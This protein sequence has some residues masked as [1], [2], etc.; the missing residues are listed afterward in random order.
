LSITLWPTEINVLTDY[1]DSVIVF[2]FLKFYLFRP[3]P[4]AASLSSFFLSVP[5]VLC[6]FFLSPP[7]PSL[8]HS[9]SLSLSLSHS[10]S[11]S[12][13]HFYH[14][15]FF[16]KRV[17]YG[18][19][20]YRLKYTLAHITYLHT[21]RKVL[22]CVSKK[23]RSIKLTCDR[24]PIIVKTMD[25]F[26]SIYLRSRWNLSFNGMDVRGQHLHIYQVDTWQREA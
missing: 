7:P 23:S 10:L 24:P 9:L 13:F 16:H 14:S 8:T 12:L 18:K 4:P 5:P 1:D 6:S 15:L 2:S 25:S 11:L 20:F 21:L 26:L 3:L 19:F 17:V 22:H